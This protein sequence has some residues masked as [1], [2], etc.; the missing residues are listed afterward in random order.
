M[1]AYRL[2]GK[3]K[4]AAA[5]SFRKRPA[6]VYYYPRLAALQYENR[7]ERICTKYRHFIGL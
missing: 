4:W 2:L 3:T 7:K 5:Q 1:I 6:C